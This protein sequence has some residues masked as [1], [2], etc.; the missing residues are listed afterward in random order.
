MVSVTTRPVS[1]CTLNSGDDRVLALDR[2]G[3]VALDS[4]RIDD[5]DPG[6]A[7]F[8]PD[9]RY[10][11]GLRRRRTVLALPPRLDR[12]GEA[13]LPEGIVPFPRGFGFGPDGDLYLA[14]GVGPSGEGENTIAVFDHRGAVRTPQLVDDPELSPLDLV[15]A[16]N[17][18]IV[19]GAEAAGVSLRSAWPRAQM[20]RPRNALPHVPYPHPAYVSVPRNGGATLRHRGTGFRS[21]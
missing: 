16:P 11:V 12:V 19:V 17:G 14:S 13:V 4:G 7:V 1:S 10:Y 6:G 9:G 5:L 2:R 8:G 21:R 3:E 20:P 18:N 15:L